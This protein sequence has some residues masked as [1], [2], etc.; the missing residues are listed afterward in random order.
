MNTIYLHGAMRKR[1]GPSF[2]L[3]ARTP[4][5][6][7]HALSCQLPGFRQAV[8][9]GH[10]RIVRGKLKGGRRL[11]IHEIGVNLPGEM[12]LIA[13]PQGAGGR[14]GSTAK[15]VV[16]A[17]LVIAAVALTAGVAGIGA[18]GAAGA[19]GSGAAAA[20]SATA[21]G[22]ITGTGLGTT[23]G[24][25]LG[26]SVSAAQIGFLGASMLFAGISQAISPSPKASSAVAQDVRASF[27]FNG[28]IN[29]GEQ[30]ACVPV[31]IGRIRTGAVIVGVSYTAEDI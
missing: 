21:F 11:T 9:D 3:T 29:T 12:H 24:L 6:A 27:V 8:A 28:A 20:G 2:Q 18:A 4:A 19:A 23:V 14:G 15:I 10:W 5:E 30:G 25:G 13:A 16:G 26:L 17:V 1:F 31:A 7:I 22:A